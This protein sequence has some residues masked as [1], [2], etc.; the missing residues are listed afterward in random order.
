MS[1]LRDA[2]A[3]Y[4]AM[5]R[6]LGYKLERD[7]KLLAQ[8]LDYLDQRDETRITTGLAVA[9]ATLPTG[10]GGWHTSRLTVTRGFA[11]YLHAIDPTVE[12]P[13]PGLL[14]ERPRRATPFLYS[15]Q[16]IAGL[17]AACDTLRTPHRAATYRIL[18][19][20]LAV[21]GMRVGEAIGL[22]RLDFDDA[23]GAVIVRGAKHGKSRELPLHPSAVDAVSRYLRR[24]D[25]PTRAAGEPALLVSSAGTRLLIT[26]VQSTFRTLRDR[27]AIKPRSRSCRPT[28]HNLRHTFAVRTILDGYRENADIGPRLAL[29]STYLGHVDPAKTYWYLEAAPELM[30]HAGERLERH[31]GAGS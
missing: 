5:R 31:L 7:G 13:A 14:P 28:I 24:G 30:H 10:G 6:A 17:L 23:H 12:V 20:L 8:F 26:N 27:G 2:L 9:W 11:R 4:L 22:D 16:Q 19:G 18:F 3:D 15:E 25:R 29:L 21:T 1:P